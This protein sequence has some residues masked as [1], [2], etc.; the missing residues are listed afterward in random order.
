MKD[1][2]GSSNLMDKYVDK[3]CDLWSEGLYLL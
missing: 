2:L 3:I 1:R